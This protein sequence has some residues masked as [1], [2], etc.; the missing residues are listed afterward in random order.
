MAS[1]TAPQPQLRVQS[2]KIDENLLMYVSLGFGFCAAGKS[3]KHYQTMM[4]YAAANDERQRQI[5]LKELE[6]LPN[7]LDARDSNSIPLVFF[8]MVDRL[9]TSAK[10]SNDDKYMIIIHFAECLGLYAK[11]MYQKAPDGPKRKENV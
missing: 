8:L 3:L 6:T 9:L 7:L 10:I 2:F 11:Q 4:D 1:K 5:F